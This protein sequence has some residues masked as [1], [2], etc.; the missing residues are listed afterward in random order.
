VA[1]ADGA[2]QRLTRE[3]GFEV[4]QLALGPPADKLS[5]FQ[6]GNA[7]GIVPPVFEPLERID[8]QTRNRLTPENTYNSAHASA[9]L[10]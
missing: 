5:A 1:D 4:A 2:G 9:G 10:L 3:P 7:G 8:K 6:R